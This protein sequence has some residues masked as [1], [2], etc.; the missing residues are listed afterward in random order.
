[1]GAKSWLLLLV[2]LAVGLA[3]RLVWRQTDVPLVAP[4]AVSTTNDRAAATEERDGPG[5]MPPMERA[6]VAP[7]AGADEVRSIAM[8]STCGSRPRGC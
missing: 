2:L 1:M 6:P 5:A 3:L 8:A 4:G 7:P